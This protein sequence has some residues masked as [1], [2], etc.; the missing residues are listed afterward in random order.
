M[1]MRW[2]C[3]GWPWMTSFLDW[4]RVRVTVIYTQNYLYITHS[5]TYP[6]FLSL[7]VL[8]YIYI[9][10]NTHTHTYRHGR[11]WQHRGQ[12]RINVRERTSEVLRVQSGPSRCKCV[13][14]CLPYECSLTPTHTSTNQFHPS[15]LPIPNTL[16]ITIHYIYT[17]R[18][19]PSWIC[20]KT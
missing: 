3:W 6:L 20:A 17:H 10:T 8:P 15:N 1:R 19:T 11:L 18:Y 7:Y 9:L 16:Y 12:L 14:V 4:P 5:L 13:C 2:T